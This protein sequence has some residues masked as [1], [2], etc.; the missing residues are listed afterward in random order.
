MKKPKKRSSYLRNVLAGRKFPNIKIHKFAKLTAAQIVAIFHN[1]T[2]NI[3]TENII[4]E[5][6]TGDPITEPLTGN[7]ITQQ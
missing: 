2:E 7:Y 6:L 3:I 1:N 4:T 5:P